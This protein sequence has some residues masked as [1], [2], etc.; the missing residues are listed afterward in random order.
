M[1]PELDPATLRQRAKRGVVFLALRTA[2]VQVITLCGNIALARQLTAR[3]FGLFGVVQFVL[4]LL[5]LLGDVGL[6]AALIQRPQS[7]TR[8]ELS[9]VFW[10]QLGLGVVVVAAAMGLTPWLVGFW[11]DLPADAVTLVQWLSL[12]FVFVMW[13]A[14]PSVLRSSPCRPTRSRA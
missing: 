8:E 11:P 5:T 10:L 14:I 13:R 7:P 1:T 9:S 12:S 3:E 4:S 6:G 2:A